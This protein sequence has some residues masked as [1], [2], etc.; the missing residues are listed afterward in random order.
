M[1]GCVS[2][3]THI[4][5]PINTQTNKTRVEHIGNSENN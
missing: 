3:N 4:S 1:G 2:K 5:L